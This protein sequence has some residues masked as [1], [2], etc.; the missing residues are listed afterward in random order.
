M[1]NEEIVKMLVGSAS[2]GADARTTVLN[3][4]FNNPIEKIHNA[5]L[6]TVAIATRQSFEILF[7]LLQM[8]LESNTNSNSKELDPL[9]NRS[10]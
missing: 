9:N 6:R 3:L 5:E 8:M 2:N 4:L 10:A 1:R 7:S